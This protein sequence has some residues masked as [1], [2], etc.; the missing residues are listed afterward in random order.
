MSGAL[1]RLLAVVVTLALVAVVVLQIAILSEERR[2]TEKLNAAP[3]SSSAA[4]VPATTKVPN[5]AKG[6]VGP[7]VSGA[8]AP[9]AFSAAFANNVDPN[10]VLNDLLNTVSDK[11]KTDAMN[12]AR[13]AGLS[14][15]HWPEFSTSANLSLKTFSDALGAQLYEQRHWEY[16]LRG[17][18]KAGVS[19]RVIEMLAQVGPSIRHLVEQVLQDP[20]SGVAKTTLAGLEE[21]IRKSSDNYGADFA[22]ALS[23]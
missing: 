14:E 17:L 20:T 6:S 22:K 16:D 1:N 11:E 13:A 8:A 15:N 3:V 10:K 21:A 19:E 12:A 7:N 18:A 5:G 23:K 2:Q 4:K 9:G